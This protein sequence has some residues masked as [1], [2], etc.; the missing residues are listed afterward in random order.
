M[1]L[2]TLGL[3]V[4]TLVLLLGVVAQNHDFTACQGM[5]RVHQRQTSRRGFHPYVVA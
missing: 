3:Q 1:K 5:V 4:S 2:N